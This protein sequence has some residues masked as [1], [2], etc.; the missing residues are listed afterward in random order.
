MNRST[1][2]DH[3]KLYNFNAG[4]RW[5]KQDPAPVVAVPTYPKQPQGPPW[6][7]DPVPPE[8]PLGL[9]VDDLPDMIAPPHASPASSETGDGG[10]GN[11]ASPPSPSLS[12]E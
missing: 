4:G 10:A 8:A 12:K 3:A 5:A 1:L 11:A 6:V 7:G 9:R 2:R